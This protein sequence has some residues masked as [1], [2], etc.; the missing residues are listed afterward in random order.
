MLTPVER[1]ALQHADV[2]DAALLG[3]LLMGLAWMVRNAHH[4]S[5]TDGVNDEVIVLLDSAR[6]VGDCET[7]EPSKAP[8]HDLV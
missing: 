7:P 5:V 2:V 1:D 4:D 8:R 6:F 3:P